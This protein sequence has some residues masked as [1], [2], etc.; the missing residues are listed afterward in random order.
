MSQ[1]LLLSGVDHHSSLN[2]H[3][4]PDSIQNAIPPTSYSY[5]PQKPSLWTSQSSS[6]M[7]TAQSFTARRS[8]ASNLPTFQLPPPDHLSALHT[9]YPAYA[10]TSTTQSTP[11]V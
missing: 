10:P 9:K 8:A 1:T 2:L 5:L 6:M 3:Y 4:S 11:A 7:E